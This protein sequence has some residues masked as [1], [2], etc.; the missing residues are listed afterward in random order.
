MRSRLVLSFLIVALTSGG[1]SLSR[2]DDQQDKEVQDQLKL[3][4]EKNQA[5]KLEQIKRNEEKLK[6]L[7]GQLAEV[8]TWTKAQFELG[9]RGVIDK[10]KVMAPYLQ[11]LQRER[12]NKL[13]TLL[14]HAEKSGGA[15]ETGQAL[16]TLLER[17]GPAAYQ[18]ALTRKVDPQ[19]ALSLYEATAI[20]QVDA[21]V[22]AR[23]LWQGKTTGAKSTS[24]FNGNPLDVEWPSLL[25]EERW[26][27]YRLAI[28]KSFRQAQLELSTSSGLQVKTAQQLRDTVR[29]LN[30]EFNRYQ[31][32]RVKALSDGPGYTQEEFRRFRDSGNLIKQLIATVYQI[33]E[34]KNLQDIAPTEEFRGGN[35][36]ELLAYMHRNNLKFAAPTKG[37]DRQAYYRIFDMMARYYLDLK[38]IANLEEQLEYDVDRL[39]ETNRQA[40]DVALGL[41]PTATEQVALQIEEMK[42]LES[43]LNSK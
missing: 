9:E 10:P 31:R 25:R 22:L 6:E 17:I 29:S 4:R 23:L 19:R 16:N 40:T 18:H 43:I 20:A 41:A 32:E 11:R 38:A 21:D 39:K 7:E 35:I 14:Q 26:T 13:Y 2:A 27:K 3:L 1:A 33:I 12:E 8:K 30:E 24:R 37:T 5:L 36:E 42:F 28:E 15:I 34:A